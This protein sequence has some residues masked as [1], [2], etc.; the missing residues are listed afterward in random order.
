MF[1][2]SVFH[3]NNFRI[4][5]PR[6]YV[7]DTLK[8]I[9]IDPVN[10]KIIF[11]IDFIRFTV[12]SFSFDTFLNALPIG[13]FVVKNKDM[14]KQTLLLGQDKELFDGFGFVSCCAWVENTSAK[15]HFLTYDPK[16]V[17]F[18]KRVSSLALLMEGNKRLFF[19]I[20]V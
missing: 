12:K 10:S 7:H 5:Y 2:Y 18:D 3:I 17:C 14:T 4:S 13:P 6:F 1:W 19:Q 8:Q 9:S 20:V 15:K 16:A 11:V